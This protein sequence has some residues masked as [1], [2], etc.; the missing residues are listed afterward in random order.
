MNLDSGE[1][2]IIAELSSGS[3]SLLRILGDLQRFGATLKRVS[4]SDACSGAIARLEFAAVPAI[5]K[6]N[7]VQ[8]LTRHPG[9]RHVAFE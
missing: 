6:D 8:R 3:D 2:K 7:L 4:W 5:E 9:V 1:L